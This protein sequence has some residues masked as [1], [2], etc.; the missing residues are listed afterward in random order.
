VFGQAFDI[1]GDGR[2]VVVQDPTGAVLGAWQPRVHIGARRVNDPGCFTWNELQ[3]RDAETAADFYAELFGWETA[4]Q[5]D[6][7]LAYMSLKNAGW[8]T[9]GRGQA[10]DRAR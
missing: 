4:A 1:D 3:S 5:E 8:A 6:G 9:E 7:K 2:M 10:L